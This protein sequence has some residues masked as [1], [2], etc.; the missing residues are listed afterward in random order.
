MKQVCQRLE[1]SPAAGQEPEQPLAV[2]R[3]PER[4]PLALYD[5]EYGSGKFVKQTE[6]IPCDLMFRIRPNRKLRR[7]PP[8]YSGRGPRPKHGPVF[9]LGDPQTWGKASE[10]WKF[11]DPKLGRVRIQRWNNLHFEEAPKRLL[12]L[13]RIERL[14]ARGTR[15]DPRVVWLGYCGQ[16]LPRNSDEWREYLNRFVIEH[17]YRFI[18]QSLNWTL[19]CLGT[20]E[21]SELW[22]LLVI[23]AYCQLWLAREVV[24]DCPRPWQKSQPELTPGRVHQA[25]GGISATMG[26]PASEPKPRGNSPGWPPGRLRTKR[27]RYPVVKKQ[28]K[29]VAKTSKQPSSTQ[30]LSP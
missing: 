3:R 27:T 26:T 6:G 23:I 5:A 28:T 21:Q 24:A 4:R 18:K 29:A 8:P 17:W 10:E 2:C 30:N 9:R 15:R 11:D 13:C 22:S 25:M 12:T 16:E 1:Q 14:E 19:P 20:P 7:S